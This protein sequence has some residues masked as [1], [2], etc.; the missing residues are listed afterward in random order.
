MSMNRLNWA[1]FELISAADLNAA[2]VACSK[3]TL[4]SS[5][6]DF[7][8]GAH[9]LI[10]SGAAVAPAGTPDMTVTVPAG[11]VMSR[12]GMPINIVTPIVLDFAAV[13]ANIY[14][15]IEV[16]LLDVDADLQ[17]RFFIDANGNSYVNSVSKR[18]EYQATARIAQGSISAAPAVASG[19][20]KIAE[21]LWNGVSVT[22]A[23]I[24]GVTQ[25]FRVADNT[26]WTTEPRITIRSKV[27]HEHRN[28]F[29]HPDDSITEPKLDPALRNKVNSGA[30]SDFTHD[31]GIFS[32]YLES[33]LIQFKGGLNADPSLGE[34]E[35][36]V[37]RGRGIL[38]MVNYAIDVIGGAVVELFFIPTDIVRVP[39]L[40]TRV[41]VGKTAA[42]YPAGDYEYINFTSGD[43]Q[44]LQI[45]CDANSR[46]TGVAD[47]RTIGTPLYAQVGEYQIY[48]DGEAGE[49]IIVTDEDGTVLPV[50]LTYDAELGGDLNIN[51]FTGLIE[52]RNLSIST[53]I[54][55]QYTWGKLRYDIIEISSAGVLSVITGTY[56]TQ[57]TPLYPTP[58]PTRQ[59]LFQIVVPKHIAAEGG[60]TWENAMSRDLR[61]FASNVPNA[62]ESAML[63]G[64]AA[65]P[66]GGSSAPVPRAQRARTVASYNGRG[67]M[68]A[69]VFHS[70]TGEGNENPLAD[71][72]MGYQPFGNPYGATW[73]YVAS[74]KNLSRTGAFAG[75]VWVAGDRVYISGGAGL[76][77]GWYE[78]ASKLN[79]DE[80]I[81][82]E[83]AGADCPAT[84]VA[85]WAYP[86]LAVC[87][88]TTYRI[89]ANSG[90]VVH[91]RWKKEYV[92]DGSTNLSTVTITRTL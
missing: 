72:S 11:F 37:N 67:E 35:I 28:S 79:D 58:T 32:E 60:L 68:S 42:M 87:I 73:N 17:D 44:Q 49:V 64:A 19:W 61:L 69:T 50:T 40:D 83:D 90:N 78:I 45:P 53:E 33:F 86:V 89:A 48:R 34:G 31:N 10:I 12:E 66:V 84:D 22:A 23:E 88:L 76:T 24:K 71:I 5:L 6:K 39:T 77:V 59:P 55:L 27:L 52:R 54:Q 14:C 82:V 13:P 57:M 20:T 75:Y 70:V 21:V 47:G 80:I 81:L 30:P 91:R 92:Y 25:F 1:A 46:D 63:S 8:I 62:W 2:G 9:D 65:F 51:T 7:I 16:Q 41:Q 26:G 85:N 15:S 74:T 56:D 38:D 43:V 18:V 29:D 3:E 36:R 4:A